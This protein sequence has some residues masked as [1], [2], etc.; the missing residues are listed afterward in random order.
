MKEGY[1]RAPLA[2]PRTQSEPDQAQRCRSQGDCARM[3]FS[4][5]TQP[6]RGASKSRTCDYE[7]HST[8]MQAAEYHK[9]Q[10]GDPSR[11]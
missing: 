8:A 1:K 11:N 7:S 3:H 9:K 2:H 5:I 6:Q 4:C 10:R